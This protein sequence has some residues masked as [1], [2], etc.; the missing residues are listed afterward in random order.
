MDAKKNNLAFL[1]SRYPN[2]HKL[3]GKTVYYKAVEKK[4]LYNW[5]RN[6]SCVEGLVVDLQRLEVRGLV[7]FGF[8]FLEIQC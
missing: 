6:F 8:S 2:E 1:Q 5:V 4:L 7:W 3:Y